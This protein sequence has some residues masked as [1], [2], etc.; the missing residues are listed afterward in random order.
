MN[1][2]P[3]YD[4]KKQQY[5]DGL[6]PYL[7]KKVNGSWQAVLDVGCGAGNLGA[8]LEDRGITVYGIEAFPEAAQKAEA[9]L[10]HV[11]CGDIESAVLPY[12][13]EQFDCILFGDVLEH[14]VDP[15][16][17][18][19]KLR[20]YLKKDGT[21]L[22]CVPNVGHISVVLELLAGK[23]TYRE[24]G[25]MDQTHLRFFTR[26][27]LVSLFKAGGYEMK[28]IEAIRVDHPSYQQAI[29]SL[30][31]VCVQLGI[32]HD[33]LTE[34]SAYQYVIEAGRSL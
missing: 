16:S 26:E 10:S 25:L 34:A 6:N 31:E 4:E 19:K 20:P 21:V 22:A 12:H 14:L 28:S 18:L 32:R 3:Y 27:E 24:S 30:H 2:N 33:F 5:Y 17:V 8:A 11:V 9:K 7:L 23:W 1:T 29:S 13:A 15:W